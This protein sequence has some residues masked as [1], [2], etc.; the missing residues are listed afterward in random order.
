MNRIHHRRHVRRT[1]AVLG[2]L[3]ASAL[4]LVTG[5]SAAVAH[6]DPPVPGPAAPGLLPAPPGW[7][8]HP[9]LPVPA[10]T[11]VIGGMPGWQI[12][13]IAIG[14]AILAAALAV[15][16]DRAHTGHRVHDR[17]KRLTSRPHPDRA[18]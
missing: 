16:L 14:A 18:A 4:S 5:A 9:P 1:A 12:T 3:A 17:A 8:K 6:P 15:T 7:A 2:A 11:A 10:H 13:L